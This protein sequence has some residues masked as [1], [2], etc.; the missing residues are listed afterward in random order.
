MAKEQT[1]SRNRVKSSSNRRSSCFLK[2]PVIAVYRVHDYP[3]VPLGFTKLLPFAPGSSQ[4]LYSSTISE[5]S[6]FKKNRKTKINKPF[7]G[8]V[9]MVQQVMLPLAILASHTGASWSPSS[10][11]IC[12]GKQWSISLAF[13]PLYLHGSPKR[14]FCLL[15]LDLSSS[16]HCNYLGS[17]PPDGGTICHHGF[18]F[19]KL[20]FLPF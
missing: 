16:G 14:S 18:H 12:L 13:G 5:V 20:N 11:V 3:Q 4:F 1:F 6:L 17:E 15:V 2:M 9:A 10:L 7:S 19:Q 8:A